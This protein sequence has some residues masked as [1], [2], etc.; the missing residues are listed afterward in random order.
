[1]YQ[2][3]PRYSQRFQFLGMND[4]CDG[5]PK[6]EKWNRQKKD[7]ISW[8]SFDQHIHVLQRL[9]LLALGLADFWLLEGIWSSA[10]LFSRFSFVLVDFGFLDFCVH[11]LDIYVIC[12]LGL[13]WKDCTKWLRFWF[14]FVFFSYVLARRYALILWWWWWWPVL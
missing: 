12:L 10:G 14:F 13:C 6:T 1:M 9:F 4:H 11:L 3:Y 5:K 8:I 2:L 7:I